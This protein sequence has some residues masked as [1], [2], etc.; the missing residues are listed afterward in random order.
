MS[1]P[2]PLNAS[3]SADESAQTAAPKG[4]TPKKRKLPPAPKT[5]AA[6]NLAVAEIVLRGVA[7]RMRGK[8]NA[9]ISKTEA[10]KRKA[11][12]KDPVD[13]R[14]LL[15]SVGL[16]GAARLAQR[17][18]GGLGL[19]AGGLLAKSLYERGKAVRERRLEQK[20]KSR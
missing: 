17:S 4:K 7:D 3:R 5:G 9:D 15:T 16:Y 13:G 8:V 1:E 18:R 6:V 11:G 19:V 20:S 12:E 10:E 2:D 14:S